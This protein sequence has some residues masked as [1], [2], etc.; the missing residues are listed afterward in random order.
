M[1]CTRPQEFLAE[2]LQKLPTFKPQ[3]LANLLNA[4]GRLAAA[5]AS[6]VRPPPGWA[7]VVA[8]HMDYPLPGASKTRLSTFSGTAL[9]SAA[10]GLSVLGYQPT[11]KVCQTRKPGRMQA[12]WTSS[13]CNYGIIVPLALLLSADTVLQHLPSLCST[14]SGSPPP[15]PVPG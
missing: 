6:R 2:V 10:W 14:T 4:M 7:A 5:P 12:G 13:Q 1:W 11:P 9:A 15:P 8:E 3:H